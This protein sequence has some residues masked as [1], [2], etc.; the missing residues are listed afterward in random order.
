MAAA[1]GPPDAV[2]ATARPENAPP[3]TEHA[4]TP[5]PPT[6]PEPPE[7]P[8]RSDSP[9]LAALLQ[10]AAVLISADSLSALAAQ[11]PAIAQTALDADIV[12][13]ALTDTHTDQLVHLSTTGLDPDLAQQWAVLP[14]SLSSPPTDAARGHTL[15]YEDATD[16]AKDY[17]HLRTQITAIGYQ[18]MVHFPL[19][20]SQ[21]TVGA[22]GLAWRSRRRFGPHER[23][24]MQALSAFTAQAVARLRLYE[25]QRRNAEVLQRSL[26]PS[27]PHVPY[28]DVQARYVPAG[29][30]EHVGGKR[31]GGKHVGGEQV[32]GD[33]YD[34][35]VPADGV[36]NIVIGDVAGHDIDAAAAMGQLRGLLRAFVWDRSEPVEAVITRLERAISGLALHL[37]ASLLLARIH[38]APEPTTDPAAPTTA[39]PG[40][41][42][43]V[44]TAHERAPAGTLVW[45][46]AGHPPPVLL[47]PDGITSVLRTTAELIVGVDPDTDRSSHHAVLPAG[48][49]VF[50][51]TDGLIESRRRD[52]DE[53][54]DAL[55]ASIRAH[56]HLP[57]EQLCDRIIDDLAGTSPEDDCAL[58]ALRVASSTD[59]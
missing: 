41:G 38:W 31:V 52:L 6:P 33:W 35:T 59:G 25:R 37:H 20:T 58:L 34:I 45:T 1:W 18:A 8:E 51:V 39:D 19:R 12:L 23:E 3:H 42:A 13:L 2:N 9:A 15:I 50:L 43:P 44:A 54:I 47:H 36:P 26:L 48:T 16:V 22:L 11:V 24:V 40:G 29:T 56:R 57:L 30:D 5:C 49:T 28:L 4:P 46:N 27:L 7:Q 17:P 21:D 53:G 14:M 32:G 55:C 10:L